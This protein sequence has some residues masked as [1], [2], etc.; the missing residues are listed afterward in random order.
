MKTVRN[1]ATTY[2]EADET[3]ELEIG[4]WLV[5]RVRHHVTN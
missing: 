2:N 5:A 1:L 3:V 4:I